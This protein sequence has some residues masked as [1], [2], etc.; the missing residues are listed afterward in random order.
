M[1]ACWI[2]IGLALALALA[3]LR[4]ERRRADY[5]AACLAQPPAHDLPPATVIVPVKGQDEGLSDNLAALA[6]LDYPDYELIVVARAPQDVPSGVVPASARLVLAG[7]APAGAGEKIHNLLAALR[8]ARAG[9]EILAFAD[10]DGRVGAGWLRALV[11]ALARPNVGAATGYRW[12]LPDPPDFWSLVRAVWDSVI[13][14]RFGP[15]EN[16]FAWG[17][18]MAIRR[19]DFI[20]LRV[21]DFWKGSV[22]DDYGLSAAVRAGGLGI[23]WAPGALVATSG[24]TSAA[25]LVGWIRRQ[26]VITRVYQPGLWWPGFLAHLV[27][28]GAMAA[29]V[30]LMFQGGLAGEYALV[31]QWGLGMLKGVN[32]ATLARAALP[33]YKPWFDRHG[34]VFA[35]W[36]PLATWVWLY[37][38]LA[39]AAG[40]RIQWRGRRYRLSNRGTRS[41]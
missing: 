14:G 27:Y 23:A 29:A 32:R 5:V 8:E 33:H 38:F 39:S 1:L 2:L 6:A 17:G 28:C 3:S 31:A 30:F 24:H 7:E 25:E 37:A 35:W 20:R 19:E 36:T 22:S 13:A 16:R 4:G 18:A 9:S 41:F 12:H 40:N 11:A 21:E 10:S 34:W 15:G 26:M